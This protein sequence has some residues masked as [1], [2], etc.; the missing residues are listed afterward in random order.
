[1]T[2]RCACDLQRIARAP[3]QFASG[4]G[5]RMSIFLADP[6]VSGLLVFFCPFSVAFPLSLRS[7]ALFVFF[8]GQRTLWV[9]AGAQPSARILWGTFLPSSRT[10]HTMG[11]GP[12]G[13][14]RWMGEAASLT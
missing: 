7:L 2:P 1:M 4:Q 3:G 11:I 14:L 8:F 5:M 9:F 12:P 6:L 13:H 10:S